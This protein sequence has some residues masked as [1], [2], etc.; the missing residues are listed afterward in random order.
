MS[1]FEDQA[2]WVTKIERKQSSQVADK[3]M[4][5]TTKKSVHLSEMRRC[6]QVVEPTPDTLCIVRPI[7]FGELLGIIELR[8]DSIRWEDDIHECT[9]VSINPKG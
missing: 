5:P 9:P 1:R 4:E 6:P 7:P 2:L 8:S 3:W